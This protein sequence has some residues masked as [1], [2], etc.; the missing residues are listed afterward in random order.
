[1]RALPLW[2]VGLALALLS[3]LIGVAWM[4]PPAV[5]PLDAPTETFSG[6]RAVASLAGRGRKIRF[7]L[8]SPL[9]LAERF[10]AVRLRASESESDEYARFYRFIF[11][12]SW[13]GFLWTIIQIVS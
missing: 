5:K 3:W 2:P 7:D 12:P 6:A 9:H 8:Y 10:R 1:M 13:G 4:A 11:L